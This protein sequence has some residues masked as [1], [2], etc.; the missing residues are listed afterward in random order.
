MLICA[1]VAAAHR[2]VKVWSEGDWKESRQ[3]LHNSS[4]CNLQ[5]LLW[6]SQYMELWF[7]AAEK[8]ESMDLRMRISALAVLMGGEE[9]SEFKMPFWQCRYSG[10]QS[11]KLQQ[12]TA[13]LQLCCEVFR[14]VWSHTAGYWATNKYIIFLKLAWMIKKRHLQGWKFNCCQVVSRRR[15]CPFTAAITEFFQCICT[16]QWWQEKTSHCASV[17]SF[18]MSV[19]TWPDVAVGK[20][21]A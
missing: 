2:Y 19:K 3:L 14:K 15:N 5:C 6:N 18:G 10:E 12:Q 21:S 20:R 11:Q 4:H 17:S 16:R 9:K 7:T 1:C 8:L 13:Q